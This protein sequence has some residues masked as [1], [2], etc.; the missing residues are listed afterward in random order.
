MPCEISDR[1]RRIDD[2]LMNQLTPADAEAFEIH[3][4]GCKECL[5]ALRLREQMIEVLKN[6]LVAV[7]AEP[8]PLRHSNVRKGLVQSIAEFFNV[9]PNAWIY[10]GFATI[11]IVAILSFPLFQDKETGEGYAA[12]FVPSQRLE[13]LVGQAQRSSDLSVMIISPH[14]GENLH[15]EIQFRWQITRDEKSIAMPLDLKILDNHEAVIYNVRTEAQEY[16]L[17]EQLAPGVYY[18]TLEYEGDMLY[19]GKI[20]WGKSAR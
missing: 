6:R 3:L 19:L 12:N 10:A 5:A 4:F 1:D 7:V 13:S 20:F 18:W 15:G 14:L 11:L 2:F 17:R 8:A 9:L 16:R